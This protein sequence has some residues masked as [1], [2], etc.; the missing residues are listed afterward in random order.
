MK[1][2]LIKK[3]MMRLFRTLLLILLT[4]LFSTGQ[5]PVYQPGEKVYYEI[6]YGI[7]Q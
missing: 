6:R 3:N 1:S 7:I 4:P 2:E 5:E